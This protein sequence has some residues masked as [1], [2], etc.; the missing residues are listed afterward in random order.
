[1]LPVRIYYTWYHII[2]YLVHFHRIYRWVTGRLQ[3]LAS[4]L[5]AQPTRYRP[6][7]SDVRAYLAAPVTRRVMATNYRVVDRYQSMEQQP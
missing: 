5:I 1:M 3:T 7:P 4:S 2:P 6:L